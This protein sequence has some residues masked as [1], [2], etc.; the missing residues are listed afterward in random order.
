MSEDKPVEVATEPKPKK[1]KKG[2]VVL[3]TI[4]GIVVVAG[5]GLFVWH[6]QPSFCNAICHTPMD[7]YLPTY[8]AEPG[9]A[10]K[11]KW[12]NDVADASGM[13]AA[14]HRAAGVESGDK[15]TCM[16]CHVPT[17]SEQ[18]GE[19]ISWVSGNYEVVDNETFGMVIGERSLTQLVAAR[20]LASG[21]EFCLN[22][23]CHDV[24]R[25]GLIELTAGLSASRNPH[26]PQHGEVSC[27]TCHKAHRASVNYC[28][29][30]HMDAPIPEGWLTSAEE[31]QLA[32][33]AK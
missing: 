24:T 5:I 8:E 29:T 28:S 30:C 4:L 32:A 25:E 23:D 11:D 12:G 14:A 19:G 13:L 3:F 16:R 21:D 18:V 20:G 17:L 26:M 27:D 2:L 31:K 22:P 33:T 1:K 6:N 10:A 9:Q 15:I 7:P